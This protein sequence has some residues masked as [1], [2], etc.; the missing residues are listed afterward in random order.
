MCPVPKCMLFGWCFYPGCIS[1]PGQHTFSRWVNPV[2]TKPFSPPVVVLCSPRT[3]DPRLL[4]N[5]KEA[6]R[7]RDL[8]EEATRLKTFHSAYQRMYTKCLKLPFSKSDVLLRLYRG[9][10]ITRCGMNLCF[11]LCKGQH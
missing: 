5:N 1:P 4:T 3:Q 6:K 11:I 10:A 9:E 7:L 8:T 2:G